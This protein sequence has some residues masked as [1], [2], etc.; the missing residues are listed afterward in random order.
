MVR[1]SPLFSPVKAPCVAQS[2]SSC[3]R[4][5]HPHLTGTLIQPLAKAMAKITKGVAI[6]NMI[7]YGKGVFMGFS[8]SLS[9]AVCQ[10][11]HCK[12]V[13]ISQH[14]QADLWH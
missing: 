7:M 14:S 8:P 10:Y 9:P 6:P 3:R 13:I 1:E 5:C 4:C 12:L 2:S 11:L